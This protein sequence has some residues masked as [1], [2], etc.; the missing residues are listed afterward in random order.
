MDQELILKAQILEQQS[1]EVEQAL[2]GINQQIQ[3]LE[4]FKDS[5]KGFEEHDGEML[6]LL[7][8]GV[9]AKTKLVEKELFVGVGADIFVKKTAKETVKVI[10]VQLIRLKEAKTQLR[11]RAESFAIAFQELLGEMHRSQQKEGNKSK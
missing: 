1:N 11:A 8:K 2:E 3:E 4:Q 6:S 5:L 7:G 9:Y 10:D